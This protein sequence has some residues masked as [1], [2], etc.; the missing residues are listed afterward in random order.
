MNYPGQHSPYPFHSVLHSMPSLT[1][2]ALAL[3]SVA[4]LLWNRHHYGKSRDENLQTSW[5]TIQT[6]LLVHSRY[7]WIFSILSLVLT[8]Y[9]DAKNRLMEKAW[10]IMGNAVLHVTG[11]DVLWRYH[12]QYSTDGTSVEMNRPYNHCEKASLVKTMVDFYI[13]LFIHYLLYKLLTTEDDQ[14]SQD[15]KLSFVQSGNVTFFVHINRL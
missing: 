2:T 1:P 5:W 10:N 3:E 7:I 8:N 15:I 11:T 4:P 12:S 6:L 14:P 13:I 9:F